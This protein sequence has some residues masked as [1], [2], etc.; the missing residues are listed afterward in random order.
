MTTSTIPNEPTPTTQVSA[1]IRRERR[2]S[3]ITIEVPLHGYGSDRNEAYADLQAEIT[4]FKSVVDELGGK[5]DSWK[6]GLPN[7]R[8]TETEK[9]FRK[10]VETTVSTI[11]TIS[12]TTSE[13]FGDVLAVLL[14]KEIPFD[15]PQFDYSDAGELSPDDYREVC[16]KARAIAEAASTGSGCTLGKVLKIEFPSVE[17]VYETYRPFRRTQL[18]TETRVLFESSDYAM[19]APDPK[20]LD[21]LDS[22]VPVFDDE[23][24]VVVTYE[25][26]N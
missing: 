20:I 19:S 4:Q 6:I 25:L 17:N 1:S 14:T 3:T 23:F 2:P 12:V 9:T 7:E 26:V 18:F 15:K 10:V 13:G 21:L 8:I 11:A 24:T 16:A 5:V 22:D